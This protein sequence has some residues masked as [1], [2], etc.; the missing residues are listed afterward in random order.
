M[1][2]ETCRGTAESLPSRSQFPIR[3]L[4]VEIAASIFPL[5]RLASLDVFDKDEEIHTVSLGFD[6][7]TL[8]SG[9][10]VHASNVEYSLAACLT[11]ADGN[12]G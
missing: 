11:Y 6:L 10:L 12:P 7:P 3:R 4:P 8:V 9:S 2:L 1:H 5:P